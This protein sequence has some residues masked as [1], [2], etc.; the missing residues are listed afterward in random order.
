M[1]TASKGDE[2]MKDTIEQYQF[3]DWFQKHRPDNFTY[4]GSIALFEYLE[5]LEADTGED[6]E[7]DPIAFCC[8]YSEYATIAEC[9]EQY[10]NIETID[11]LRDHT[12]VIEVEG[13]DSIII[14]AF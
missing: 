4:K 2:N 14:Q 11:D 8:E 6:M 3:V 9:L 5:D 12:T 10:D 7:F 1:A 13:S